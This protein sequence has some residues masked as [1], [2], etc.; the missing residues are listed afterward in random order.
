MDMDFIIIHKMKNG[1]EAAMEIFVRSYYPL[2]LKYCCYHTAVRDYAE[3][4]TQETFERFFRSL[5][6]YRHNGKAL[7]YLY[8][9]AGN[10]CRDLYKREVRQYQEKVNTQGMQE[11]RGI[12]MDQTEESDRRL[13]MERA[14]EMLTE[15]L[16]EVIILYYFQ[17]L[18]LREVADVLKI[19]LPLVKYRIRKAKEILGEFLKEEGNTI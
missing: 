16:R 4:I 9:I 17:Q 6:D 5:P 1:D 13:D 7:N 12:Q 8:T 11:E 18:K 3:D 19:G 14:L 10:L 15:D 2:I